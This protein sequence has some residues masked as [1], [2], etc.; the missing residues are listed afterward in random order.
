MPSMT[1]RVLLPFEVFAHEQGVTSIVVETAQGS[2]GL[3]PQRRDAWYV[4]R[5]VM[6]TRN[7]AA[8]GVFN[9]DIGIVLAPPGGGSLRAYFLDGSVLR[10]VSLAWRDASVRAVPALFHP[11]KTV[12]FLRRY[13]SADSTRR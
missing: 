5:P 12:W 4:G 3:L 6:V 1:L 11:S 7:D 10:S 8:L 9:G 2:F 13:R